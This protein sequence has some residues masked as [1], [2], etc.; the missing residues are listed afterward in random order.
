[1]E[2]LA[3]RY[4]KYIENAESRGKIFLR[5]PCPHCRAELKADPIPGD[6]FSTC[7]YCEGNYFKI[8]HADGIVTTTKL[9]D[10]L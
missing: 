10:L 4:N 6:T 9:E 8:T 2:T 1:M 3:S 5:Y 7:P